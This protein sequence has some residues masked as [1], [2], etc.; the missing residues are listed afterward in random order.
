MIGAY[1]EMSR[2]HQLLIILIDGLSTDHI[3]AGSK[4]Q[5]V[6]YSLVASQFG[7][8]W[9]ELGFIHIAKEALHPK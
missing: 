4:S 3:S 1:L 8:T 7:F 5:I 6:N 9:R 2:N